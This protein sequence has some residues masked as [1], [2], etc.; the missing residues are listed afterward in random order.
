MPKFVDDDLEFIEVVK[1]R[2]P[3][4]D[5]ILTEEDLEETTLEEE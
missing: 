3:K 1:E 4:R 2:D 5:K